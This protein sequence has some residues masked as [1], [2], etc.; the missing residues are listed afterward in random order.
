[1][2]VRRVVIAEDGERPY[3][4]HS[5]GVARH[6]DHR[7]LLVARRIGIGLAHQD[8]DLAARVHRARGPPLPGVDDIARIAL[9][10]D[11]RLDV[12][13]VGGG[14]RRL[15]HRKRRADLALEQRLQ[16]A[17]LLFL[18]AI[19]DQRFHIAGIGRRAVEDLG[20]DRRAAQDLA[21]RRVFEVCQPGAVFAFRQEQV[22][23]TGGARLLF[24][25]LHDRRNL[26]AR[27]LLVELLFKNLLGRVDVLLHKGAH[28]CLEALHLLRR[29][30]IHWRLPVRGR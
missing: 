11:R 28:F 22:P 29:L 2:A 17:L 30:E 21:E 27:G 23:Q 25:L 8:E 24:Q 15:G 13:R 20:C 10:A 9:A 6:E 26:P 1:M 14:D 5:G 19:A 4:S 18:R 16:P 3:D 7:L 12:G